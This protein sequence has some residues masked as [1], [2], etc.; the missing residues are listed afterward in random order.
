MDSS[1]H[2]RPDQTQLKPLVV[3]LYGVPASGK[4]FLLNQL[5]E[6]LS[7]DYFLLYEGSEMINSVVP[8]GLE[9]FKEL[10]E[11]DKM[12]WRRFAIDR[13]RGECAA[14][15]QIGIVTGHLMF[16]NEEHETL[17]PIY[18][19]NDLATFSHIIYLDIPAEV[20]VE[21]RQSDIHR[22][23]A[24]MSPE[25]IQKWQLAEK[26]AL[27]TLCR[28]SCILHFVAG[29]PQYTSANT[30][31][32]MLYHI[33]QNT[34]DYNLQRA[35]ARLNDVIGN[36]DQALKTVCVFDADKTLCAEDTGTMFWKVAAEL[37]CTP[38]KESECPLKILFGSPLGYSESAFRQ[39][40]LLY[41]E[42]SDEQLFDAI[43]EEVAA[44]VTIHPE[45]AC[46]IRQLARHD[47]IKLI[48]ITCGLQHIW[49]KILARHALSDTVKI[50]GAGRM[51]EGLIVTPD[52][53]ARLVARIRDVHHLYVWAFGDSVLDLPMMIEAH[54]ALVVV[55][56]EQNRSKSMEI[57]LLKAIETKKLNAC[58]ILLPACVSPR[59]DT[60]S[61]PVV[62]L[63]D[64]DFVDAVSSRRSKAVLEDIHRHSAQIL[65]TPMRDASKAGPTLRDIHQR[66]GWHLGI[67]LM[68][69]ILGVDEYATPHVQGHLATGYRLRNEDKMLIVALMRGGEPMAL[70]VNEAFPLATFM[71]A[72]DPP[73]LKEHHL[74]GY[75]VLSLVDSVVNSGKTV[76]DFVKHIR[77]LHAIIHIVVVA[78]VVQAECSLIQ[79]ANLT[80]IALRHSNNKFTGKGATDT[81][82]RLFNT[83]HQA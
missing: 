40:V 9:V 45:F 1:A 32:A 19:E 62:H 77:K 69:A 66:V 76:N 25:H 35:E 73:D 59:L 24:T 18:T 29:S 33:R 53:K 17:Q 13:I 27:K 21:R 38:A 72:R 80:L 8:G 46:F 70:G 4:T 6:K 20:I 55:G 34:T 68:P 22:Q 42:I 79:D 11:Q 12:S 51:T 52:T 78:G 75:R 83:T 23:R 5:K 50:I 2:V 61:L 74:R 3:G 43:C 81:G 30:L 54:Q 7:G 41:E 58:Q 26:T 39:A 56:E 31:A 28:D 60:A 49:E 67:T 71:H 36:G 16:W 57:E 10:D 47:H 37:K 63:A 44:S 15:G 64:Q 82:N 48:I 65:T 14:Y